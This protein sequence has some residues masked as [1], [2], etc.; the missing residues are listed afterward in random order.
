MDAAR[1]SAVRYRYPEARADALAGVDLRLAPGE[2]VL[3]AGGSGS[4]KSTLL[5]ALC[6]LVPHFHGGSFSGRCVVAGFDSAAVPPARLCAGAGIVFQDPEAGAVMLTVEHEVA[7]PLENAAWP[8]REIRPRVVEALAACGVGRLLPRRL[9]TL[10]GG[11]LQRVALAAALAPR[12]SLLLLDEPT[13][14]LDPAGADALARAVRDLCDREGVAAVVADH[15]TARL[16]RVADRVVVLEAGRVAAD[17]R[18]GEVRLPPEAP[19]PAA[20]GAEAGETVGELVG[21]DAGHAG[22]SVL[23]GASLRLAAGTVTA[24]AG[25]NGAGK[26]TLARVLAGLHPVRAGAVLLGGEDVTAVAAERR[27]PRVGYVGQDPGRYLLHERVDDEVSYALRL[28]CRPDAEVRARCAETLVQF[29][30][31]GL[32]SRHPRDLS[33]GER[34]R[35]ALASVLCARPRLLVLDEPTRGMDSVARA[36]L[37][38]CLRDHA[39]R[40]GAVLVITHDEAFAAAVADRRAVLEDGSPREL[41]R[42]GVA[43]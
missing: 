37:C 39:A 10:S 16:E 15:R 35:V 6:G 18:P 25:R 3:L 41:V 12:P 13:S 8:A 27:F 17:G 26:T 14:Q 34:E 2:L 7:F 22:S 23:R 42:A 43:A 21:I 33:G 19:A 40:G 1:L 30:L 20:A 11:E 9:A 4:G 36:A 28:A 38:A 29:A 31:D 24:L 5:R 32:A